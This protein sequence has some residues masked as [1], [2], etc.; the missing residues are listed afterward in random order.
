MEVPKPRNAPDQLA[1]MPIDELITLKDRLDRLISTR[2]EAEKMAIVKKLDLIKRLEAGTSDA[3]FSPAA[4]RPKALPKYRNPATG[5]TWAG[6][7]QQ[8]RW[9]RTAIEAGRRQEDFRIA[10][11]G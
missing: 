3:R 1:N 2:L 4:H 9:M 10:D 7:G 8:P 11:R 6:R 5:E